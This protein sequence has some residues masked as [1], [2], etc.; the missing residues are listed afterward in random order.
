MSESYVEKFKNPILTSKGLPYLYLKWLNNWE[1][2]SV[3]H[4]QIIK[5]DGKYY[6]IYTGTTSFQQ[7]C[8]HHD[9][10]LAV[11]NDLNKWERFQK[12]PIFTRGVKGEWDGDLAAHSYIIKKDDL[13][14]LF[15]DGSYLDAWHEE[16]GVAISSDLINWQRYE[17]NPVLKSGDWWWNKN[18]VSRCC[19]FE[20]NGKYYMF[21][22][23]HDGYCERIGMAV[24]D[25]LL[26]WRKEYSEPVLDL[27]K[28]GDWDEF[29]IS[30]PRVLKIDELYLM[31]YSGYDAKEK[32]GRL[33]VAYSRDLLHWEKFKDNPI[34][35]TG[36]KSDWDSH[37]AARANIFL[38][39]NNEYYLVYSGG[40]GINFK[41]GIA[42]LNLNRIIENISV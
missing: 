2:R 1:G 3:Y 41:T 22:A 33:G 5:K 30:D 4:P 16:I 11:S 42:K 35:N 17:K 40:R 29:H 31:F 26:N 15:Y 20:E 19:V 12:K 24:S 14:Y 18:H 7:L 27:G 38:D 23:G 9:L 36:S 8:Y 34:M 37:E 13:Y 28:T 39:D 10:G 6:L 21:F 25:D 32:K